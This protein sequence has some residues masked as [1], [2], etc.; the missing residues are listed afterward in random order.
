MASLFQQL[1]QQQQPTTTTRNTNTTVSSPHS[2]G[3]QTLHNRRA[4]PSLSSSTIKLRPVS[5]LA[6]SNNGSMRHTSKRA[7]PTAASAS[8]SA[9]A[10]ATAETSSKAPRYTLKVSFVEIYNEDLVDLLNPAPPSERP[11]VTI[12]EDTKGQIYWTGV[13]EVTVENT[14]DVLRHLQMGTQHRATGSTDMNA[15]S[16]RSHAIFS[17]TLKQEKWVPNVKPSISISHRPSIIA[18]PPPNPASSRSTLL[19]RRSSTLNVRAM[20][21]QM[22]QRQSGDEDGK[23]VISNSKFH[24]VDLAGS[25]RLK[26]TAAQGD[27]RKEGININAGLLAL[28]NVISALADINAGKR[29]AHIPYRDS[30]LTRLLQDSLGGNSQTLMIACVSP[31]EANVIETIN[32]LQYA[33][34]ARSIKNKV[35]KNEAEEWL[36]ND[37]PEYLR[38]MITKLKAEIRD[39]KSPSRQQQQP[40]PLPSLPTPSVSLSDASI[41]TSSSASDDHDKQALVADL[42]RQIEELQNQVTVTRERNQLVESE[43]KRK[44]DNLDFQHLV[45]PVIEEYEK[46]ISSL[47]SQLAMARAA[48][49]HSDTAIAEQEA[50]LS[51][52]ETMH[53]S[54]KASLVE[55]KARLAKA[56]EREKVN[57]GYIA[58][59][60]AKLAKTVEEAVE[61]QQMLTDLRR[62]IVKF[63]ELDESTEEYISELE[64][65]LALS[66]KD[67][68]RLQVACEEAQLHMTQHQCQID[69]VRICLTPTDGTSPTSEPQDQAL[70]LKDLH[71][72]QKECQE[73]RNEIVVLQEKLQTTEHE[74]PQS[75]GAKSLQE[76]LDGKTLVEELRLLREELESKNAQ[77]EML[78]KQIR[79]NDIES[80]EIIGK[81]K[82]QATQKETEIQML[83]KQ[84]RETNLIHQELV[85]TR[86]AQTQ[87]IGRLESI[88]KSVQCD[89]A[90]SQE[91]AIAL[92]TEHQKNLELLAHQSQQAIIEQ[93]QQYKDILAMR[94]NQLEEANRDARALV[95]LQ[96]KQDIIIA[97]LQ[98]KM[99]AMEQLVSTLHN[100]IAD[101]DRQISVLERISEGREREVLGLKDKVQQILH[102]VR[103]V[104]L[105]RNQLDVIIQFLEAALRQQDRKAD[106]AILTLEDLQMQ[107]I[108]R[109]QRGDAS[110][111]SSQLLEEEKKSLERALIDM[112]RRAK[113]HEA[114]IATFQQ[115]LRLSQEALTEQDELMEK[116]QIEVDLARQTKDQ[117]TALEKAVIKGH[118]ER[119][120][121]NNELTVVRSHLED[122]RAAYEKESQ[123]TA[124]L[125]SNIVTLEETIATE[126]SLIAASDMAGLVASLQENLK[127]LEGM[128]SQVMHD[129]EE[130]RIHLDESHQLNQ[131]KDA[132]IQLLEASMQKTKAQL[133]EALA[134]QTEKDQ[135]IEDLQLRL[136]SRQR[137]LTNDTTTS[138][139]DSGLPDERQLSHLVKRVEE[140]ERENRILSTSRSSNS[141][142]SSDDFPQ[143]QSRQFTMMPMENDPVLDSTQKLQARFRQKLASIEGQDEI[144]DR[145]T[146]LMTE[147]S[148]LSEQVNEL[149]DQLKSQRDHIALEAKNHEKELTRLV[150]DNER[151]EK[152]L[153]QTRMAR[154][155]ASRANRNSV[156]TPPQTPAPKPQRTLSFSS[157]R[158]SSSIRSLLEGSTSTPSKRSSAQSVRPTT[159]VRDRAKS[160]HLPPPS[161]PPSNPLP[162]VPTD[163]SSPSRSVS[164]PALKRQGSTASTV[165]SEMLNSC[166][167]GGGK[168]Y[169][170]D[171]YEK[172]IQSLQRKV[173]AADHDIKVHQDA[174][175][176]LEE[177]LIR[178]ESTVREV[179]RQLETVYREKQT[180]LVELETIRSH[181]NDT[182]DERVKRLQEELVNERILKEKAEK[183]RRILESR[184]DDFMS[185][186]NNKFMCF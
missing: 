131:D 134:V 67:R 56:T 5:V 76:E 71:A 97:A 29:V 155:L 140:L 35:E 180:Y 160:T 90:R 81:F 8:A 111:E 99:D 92:Q 98:H 168:A 51:K 108:S 39:L 170:S 186:R 72:A 156:S 2:S 48:L 143:P 62:K 163:T 41:S 69:K 42:R 146:Q 167:S 18:S 107:C 122:A 182:P 1:A 136:A 175:N 91:Q 60:E 120:K 23:W 10:A 152:E 84:L 112:T 127:S 83:E 43:L 54:E 17:V 52:Y 162:P 158:K 19:D 28:G 129:L 185:K 171:Q 165:L 58:E 15:K 117:L 24:F 7:T 34:R 86:E 30:K 61:D 176:R 153:E 46:S 14:E 137:R 179:K 124:R 4:I 82:D 150:A 49:S 157:L 141:I 139:Q 121:L 100:Q 32:T 164:T 93:E 110:S 57:E 169:T 45:E 144:L 55:L 172:V 37:N 3:I 13:K 74:P 106:K 59:L 135:Q 161:A 115:Q 173:Q 40:L 26:R 118:E 65:R 6:G 36:T 96:D 16:S 166:S 149:E 77:V 114:L 125:E 44:K 27:R 12:R 174:M 177:Q 138:S 148:H 25:E 132:S 123:R 119:D 159:R 85:R 116:L 145:L 31:A 11:P 79:Q 20:I 87:E 142:V 50:K 68:Q 102:D 109:S 78:E 64:H 73:L 184:M 66:D 154:D 105:E 126:R 113:K 89:L 147:N 104:G 181:E 103:S 95:A 75:L 128:K 22:E 53:G 47:E 21:G 38:G 33:H 9:S 63:K 183:A 101:R 94:L 130:T 88:L 151:L 80:E 133:E 70:L 178:S